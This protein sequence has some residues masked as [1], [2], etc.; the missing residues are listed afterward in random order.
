[1]AYDSNMGFH[2][3]MIPSSFYENHM[4]SFQSGAV[5]SS[6]RIIPA[7]MN[8][9]GTIN[10]MEAMVYSAIPSGNNMTLAIPSGSTAGVLHLD[11]IPGLKHDTGLA[12]VWSLE[13]QASLEKGLFK[14]VVCCFCTLYALACL[15]NLLIMFDSVI[16]FGI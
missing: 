13:E 8:S 9:I 11:P 5:I 3:G 7:A 10:S 14:C 16:I 4:V 6:S 12:V 15:L 1:M 2:Q